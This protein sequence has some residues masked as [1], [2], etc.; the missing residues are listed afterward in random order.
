MPASTDDLS[1]LIGRD[2][3]RLSIAERT[4]ATGKWIA[5]EMYTPRTLPAHRIEAIGASVEECVADLHSRGLDPRKFEYTLV[6][7]PY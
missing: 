6:R 4:A 2:P 5:I 1:S 7:P 3:E